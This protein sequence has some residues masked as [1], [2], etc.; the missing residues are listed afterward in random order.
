M[1]D[2]TKIQ[3]GTFQIKLNED[4]VLN[5]RPPKVKLLKKIQNMAREN[6]YTELIEGMVLILNSN[7]DGMEFDADF[8]EDYMR[9][10]ELIE[11]YQQYFEWIAGIKSNPN[12]KSPATIKR[13]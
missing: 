1:L 12:S 4:T 9:L 10:D 13:K 7:T 6:D 5:L 11:V 2:I 8:V 3:T